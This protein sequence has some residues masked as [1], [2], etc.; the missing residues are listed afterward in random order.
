MSP[1][2]RYGKSLHYAVLFPSVWSKLRGATNRLVAIVCLVVT[3]CD[4]C[5]L[6][7]VFPVC[8]MYFL[9]CNYYDV[10]ATI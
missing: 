6:F 4:N 7:Y 10:I 1:A 5:L 9:L 8:I 2:T 3:N